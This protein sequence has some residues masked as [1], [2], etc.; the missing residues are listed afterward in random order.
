M[1]QRA[2]VILYKFTIREEVTG[3]K[4]ETPLMRSFSKEDIR[5]NIIASATCVQAV[6]NAGQ[7]FTCGVDIEFVSR[8]TDEII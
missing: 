7:A 3:M 8:K 5:N 6:C 2:T 1:I 4:Y